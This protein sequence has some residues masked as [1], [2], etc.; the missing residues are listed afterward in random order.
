MLLDG[1]V[2]TVIRSFQ[3]RKRSL[4]KTKK[5]I[6]GDIIRYYKNNRQY[7][8]YDEYLRNGYPIGSGAIEGACRHLVKDRMEQTGMRWEIEG[9]QAML[10]TRSAYINNEWG[11]LVEYRIQKQI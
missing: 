8:Q 11:D 10:N 4:S 7:M 2:D 5:K 3:A 6:L 1:E 9:A